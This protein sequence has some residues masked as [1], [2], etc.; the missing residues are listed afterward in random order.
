MYFYDL[1]IFLM[2]LSY[3][4]TH[5]NNTQIIE[6]FKLQFILNLASKGE[7]ISSELYNNI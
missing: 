6:N 5:T 2:D 3:I 7:I 4:P 1:S